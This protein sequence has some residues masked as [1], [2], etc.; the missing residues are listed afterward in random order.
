MKEP[1]MRIGRSQMRVSSSRSSE[2]R[3]HLN[4]AGTDR[5]CNCDHDCTLEVSDGVIGG[6]GRRSRLELQ[7][8]RSLPRLHGVTLTLFVHSRVESRDL[9]LEGFLCIEVSL[10]SWV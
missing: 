9:F 7:A 3:L 5:D 1:L 10:I 4:R 6:A 8:A 2:T